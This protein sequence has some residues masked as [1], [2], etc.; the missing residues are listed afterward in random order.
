MSDTPPDGQ[1]VPH[2][3]PGQFDPR[4]W[5]DKE[6]A[7]ARYFMSHSTL[8]R[9]VKAGIVRTT[10]SMGR[11]VLFYEPDLKAKM[12]GNMRQGLALMISA[13]G[14]N[15]EAVYGQDMSEDAETPVSKPWYKRHRYYS[16]FFVLFIVI[17]VWLT[18]P[19][20]FHFRSIVKKITMYSIAVVVL[21]IFLGNYVF[22]E[23][24]ENI[25]LLKTD[26]VIPRRA[27]NPKKQ[28][29]IYNILFFI[30][31]ICLTVGSG[32][33]V[34]ILGTLEW[35]KIS[36][37]DFVAIFVGIV[38]VGGIVLVWVVLRQHRKKAAEEEDEEEEDI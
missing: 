3:P 25:R 36:V 20:P 23:R 24:R 13:P 2:L 8:K 37:G 9:L 34:G 14:E 6:T 12:I 31:I 26:G 15:V 18:V 19:N 38:F 5:L 7:C 11:R 33:L 32:Y 10:S 29:I 21:G 4:D 27:E 22:S 1:R 16:E 28:G 17:M 30:T 35:L